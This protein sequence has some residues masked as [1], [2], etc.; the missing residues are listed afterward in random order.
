[1]AQPPGLTAF[2]IGATFDTLPTQTNLVR[3]KLDDNKLCGLCNSKAGTLA[4]I[5]AGCSFSLAQGR[6]RERHDAVLKGIAHGIQQTINTLPKKSSSNK[7]IQFVK[8]GESKVVKKEDRGILHS[9]S[10]W[11]LQIDG[12]TRLKF[13]V[14]IVNTL[15]RPDLI[16]TS[17]GKKILVLIELTCPMEENFQDAHCRKKEKYDELVKQCRGKGWTT[18]SF[19]VEVGARCFA[20]ESLIA[21]LRKLGLGS[22]QARKL[23]NDVTD[24][25]LRCSF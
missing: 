12:S 11:S 9:A 3:W 16:I 8:E 2:V 4:H 6:Y 1:M 5:L 23:S 7:Y 20:A 25:S 14:Q 13:P 19:A 10:S 21:C 15:L 18:Y 17:Y 24:T 22:K